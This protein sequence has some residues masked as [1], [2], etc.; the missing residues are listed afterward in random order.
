MSSSNI[1]VANAFLRYASPFSSLRQVPV[2]GGVLRFTSRKLLD[3]DAR[4]WEQIQYGPAAGLWIR[5]NPRTGQETFLG[6]CE[7]L[8][9]RAL[10]DHLRPGMTFYDLGA[11]I[12]FFSLLAARLVGPCGRVISMEPDPEL[13]VRLRENLARNQF[14]WADVQQKAVWSCTAS[15]TFARCDA[16]TSPDRGLGHVT[17]AEPPTGFSLTVEATSLDDFCSSHPEP[18]CIKCDVEGAEVQV[19]HGARNL[20]RRRHPIIIC[21]MHSQA[22]LA[23]LCRQFVDLHYDCAILD[24]NHLL[25]VP[26]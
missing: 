12:G 18:D 3:K 7:P 11:N 15:V 25:A 16:S 26:V 6:K 1:R 23:H 24:H 19:F 20:L 9:Q 21:E 2:L 10:A 5:I 22:S 4:L 14:E 8:V 13:A 17:A